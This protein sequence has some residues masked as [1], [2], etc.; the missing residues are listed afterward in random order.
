VL[1]ACTDAP[2]AIGGVQRV[3]EE[4]ARHL[5][6]DWDVEVVAPAHPGAAEYD[7]QASFV[8]RRTPGTWGESRLSVLWHIARAVRGSTAGVLVA[9]HVNVLPPLVL[10]GRGRPRAVMLYGSELWA[11]RTRVIARVFGRR[12]DRALAI[13]RFTA[14]QASL[15]GIPENRITVTPLAAD[16]LPPANI[17]TSLGPLGL[18]DPTGV[19]VPFLLTVSRLDEPHKGHAMVL[20]ALPALLRVEPGLRYVVAGSG[21]LSTELEA[22]A[23][24]IGVR[25]ALILAGAVTED[26][27][28]A[29]LRSCRVFVMVSRAQRR[30]AL[31]EG[32]GIAYL[33]AAFAA[34]PVIAGRA[35]GVEDAV[36]HGETGL[37]IAPDS[38]V[39]FVAAASRLL[40]DTALADEMG[41]RA[42]ARVRS[43]YTWEVA[44]GRMARC[45]E[46]LS[47]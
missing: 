15:A 19:V 6:L 45:L 39:E 3:V 43:G 20:R 35:G 36:V 37:L 30:P 2:P 14:A 25:D 24:E 46:G 22:L 10:N 29:L 4:L 32:F 18:V 34:R 31:F 9:A 8:I 11:P 26:V 17:E 1:I 27:K 28:S 47:T 41:T 7:Q 12:V 13:S 33:E 44:A 42:L 16:P 5:S 23:V 21:P 38:V 40:E